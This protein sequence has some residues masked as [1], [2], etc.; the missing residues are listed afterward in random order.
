MAAFGQPGVER[1]IQMLKDE[2]VLC[3]RLMGTPTIADITERHVCTRNLGDHFAPQ[4]TD[5][6]SK[7]TYEP[8]VTGLAHS[9]L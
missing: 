6:L 2:L 5:Y 8:L 9:K 7:R 1:A 3:M 4:G